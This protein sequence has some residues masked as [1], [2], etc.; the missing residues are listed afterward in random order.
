MKQKDT[1]LIQQ[2]LQGDQE[3]F[4]ILV[5]RYQK[6]VHALAW[7]KIGDFHIAEEI[8]QDAFLKA[9]HKLNTLKNHNLFAG[10]LYVIASHLCSDWHRKNPQPLES[11]ETIDVSKMKQMSYSRYIASK[12]AT[13][14]DETR[15][16]IVKKLLQK[17]PE[18]ERTV[19]TLYYFGEM[20]SETIG[21]FLGVSANTVRSRLSRARNRLKK[22]EDM[23]RHALSSFQ[24]SAYLAENIMREISRITPAVPSVKKPVVP[25]MISAASAVL[26]LFL[27]GVGT[28]HLSHFQKPYNLNATSKPT[29]EI[30]EAFIVLDAPAKPAIQNQIGNSVI[31]GKNLGAGQRPDAPLFAA[32]ATDEAEISTPKPQWIQTKGPEGGRV[33]SLFTTTPGDIYAGTAAGLYK[34]TDGKQVWQLT[35]SE[36]PEAF[37]V[38]NEIGWWRMTERRDTLYV[39]T[40]TEVFASIDRGQTWNMLGM[41]PKGLPTGI[42]ITDGIHGAGS[43]ISIYLAL[44][45]GIY[46]SEDDGKSWMPLRDG[47]VGRKIRGLATVENTVFAGTDDGLYRLKAG[48]WERLSLSQTDSRGQKLPI[49][50]LAVAGSRL[51]AAIGKQFTTEVGTQVETIMRGST[52]WSLYRSTDLGDTWHAVDPRKK[53]E[54]NRALQNGSVVESSTVV[55]HFKNPHLASETDLAPFVKIFASKATV[56]VT[57]N[58]HQYYSMNTGE[59]W[60]S[61]DLHD[62]LDDR[63]HVVPSVVMLDANTFY[64]GSETG[65]HR[66]TD[67]GQSWHQFNTG[68]ASRDVTDLVTANGK[69]YAKIT[70]GI[71][72]STDGGDSWTPIPIGGI[73][74]ITD[75]AAFDGSVYARGEKNMVTRFF[76]LSVDDD[77][78]IAILRTPNFEKV[79]PD[80]QEWLNKIEVP[81]QDAL[82]EEFKQNRMVQEPIDLED[83]DPDK[84]NAALT[85]RFQD[86]DAILSLSRLGDFVVSD[87]TYYVERGQKLFRWKPG[88]TAW[89]DTG[90]PIE[91]ARTTPVHSNKVPYVPGFQV[92][93]GLKFAVSGQT[94][95]VGTGNGV[96]FQSFDEGD[97]WNNVTADLP[98]PISRFKIIAFAGSTVYIATDKGIIYSSEGTDW[99]KTTDVDGAMLIIDKFAVDG[100]TVYGVLD[101]HAHPARQVYQL[102]EN[103]NTWKQVTPEILNRVTSLVVD[104]NT[105]YVGTIGRGVLRFTLEE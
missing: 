42:A 58:Q 65:I 37:T 79:K 25:W 105:L 23:I 70:D 32:V 104:G 84:L 67:A 29:V 3:A 31:P 85:K 20:T 89:H 99:H 66:T 14:A 15:R 16:E 97:T 71:V 12:Q 38:Y 18:S 88:V 57:D 11:L 9:Y 47:L 76:R 52:W 78:F 34:L 64:I 80:E 6:G 5:K 49:H 13:E 77:R 98:F 28:Q 51:Y 1:E 54:N 69:L 19:I 87:E 90:L 7:R 75:L 41:H 81:F 73:D 45:N 21:E 60:T 30:I 102:K 17:L 26:I 59:T 35:T 40:D 24:L 56:I 95:Y 83:Y 50:A 10:W 46:R 62:I 55:I 101:I 36:A 8:T 33:V 61:L 2:V 93:A 91:E 74:N 44:A 53:L 96:L 68:L 94:I 86:L 103:F 43:D 48:T 100:T 92:P 22:E 39:A 63:Q 4:G 27:I 82:T 72:T